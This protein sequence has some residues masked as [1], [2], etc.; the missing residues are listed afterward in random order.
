MVMQDSAWINSAA[1]ELNQ[2]TGGA[3][4]GGGRL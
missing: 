4:N 3:K 2:D 1:K